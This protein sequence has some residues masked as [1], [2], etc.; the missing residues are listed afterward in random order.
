MST[1]TEKG[2]WTHS[3]LTQH[4]EHCKAPIDW[5]PEVLSRVNMKNPQLLKHHLR[6]EEAMWIRRLNCGPGKGLN[7]DHGS[8]VKT[9]VWAPIF[10]DLNKWPRA[11][12]RDSFPLLQTD[13]LASFPSISLSPTVFFI[14][15]NSLSLIPLLNN[16][17][18]KC[19][20][21]I[22]M[23]LY[24]TCTLQTVIIPSQ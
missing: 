14:P 1:A 22:Q 9:D 11:G 19:G 5:K 16:D 12:T 15:L 17:L 4:K 8:Y 23:K 2:R 7:E 18:R 21:N 3:G 10:S 20:R 24:G 13:S 6:V